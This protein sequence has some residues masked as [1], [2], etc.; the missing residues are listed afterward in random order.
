[1]TQGDPYRAEQEAYPQELETE[2]WRVAAYNNIYLDN[3]SDAQAKGK[4][5]QAINSFL[6]KANGNPQFKRQCS[7][8]R[9]ILRT[10]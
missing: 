1:M 3:K 8:L 4:A 9:N 10:Y 7:D 2:F 6:K 5:R